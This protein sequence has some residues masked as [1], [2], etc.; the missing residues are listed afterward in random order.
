MGPVIYDGRHNIP[1]GNMHSNCRLLYDQI[2]YNSTQRNNMRRANTCDPDLKI[3]NEKKTSDI[4][5]HKQNLGKEHLD[6]HWDHRH[7]THIIW[8]TIHVL[9]NSAPPPT[10]NTS[11]T[12]NNKITTT[13]KKYCE[14]FTKLFTNTVRHRTH[15]ANLPLREEH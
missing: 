14:L 10:L 11:I 3:Q 15:M 4:Q 6:A 12:F 7:N 8:K 13:P 5:K 9:S 1:N 2:V